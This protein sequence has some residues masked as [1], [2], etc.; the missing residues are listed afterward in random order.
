MK[1]L[2]IVAKIKFWKSSI[3]FKYNQHMNYLLLSELQV[4]SKYNK[5]LCI[6]FVGLKDLA[7]PGPFHIKPKAYAEKEETSEDE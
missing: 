2:I 4:R 1:R 6:N 5:L 7:K 3:S